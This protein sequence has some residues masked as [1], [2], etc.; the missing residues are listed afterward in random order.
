MR[1]PYEK[2]FIIENYSKI[3]NK[4][5][6]QKLNTSIR[7]VYYY[8]DKFSDEEKIKRNTVNRNKIKVPVTKALIKELFLQGYNSKGI[9]R[10]LGITYHSFIELMSRKRISLVE[11]KKDIRKELEHESRS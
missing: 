6:A 10:K 7:I 5:I 3:P 9:A 4:L 1:T 2:Q 11:I 8:L